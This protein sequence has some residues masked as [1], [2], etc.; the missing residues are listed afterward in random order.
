MADR[1]RAFVESCAARLGF[2]H[3]VQGRSLQ[4][5]S[6]IIHELLMTTRIRDE[7]HLQQLLAAS[8]LASFI[9]VASA[10]TRQERTRL[11]G[12]LQKHKT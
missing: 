12:I 5:L 1:E 9:D 7:E 8:A 11:L 2:G 6:S 4:N 3:V 10:L